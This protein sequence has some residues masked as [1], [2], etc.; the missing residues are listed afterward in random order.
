MKKTIF[1]LGAAMAFTIFSCT[2]EKTTVVNHDG[3]TIMVRD[4]NMDM[5][6]QRMDSVAEKV[7]ST[8]DKAGKTIKEGAKDLKKEAEKLGDKADKAMDDKKKK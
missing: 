6:S 8:L 4:S 1:C 2:K 5:D 3:D 7:D